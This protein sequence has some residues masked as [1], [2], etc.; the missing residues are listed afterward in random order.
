MFLS[1][2]FSFSLDLKTSIFVIAILLLLASPLTAQ[3]L[4]LRSQINPDCQVAGGLP[5]LRYSDIW[6]DGNIAV[7]G[8]YNCR[9][10]F[11]YDLTDPDAPVLASVYNPTPTQ[12]FLE[13]IVVGNRGYFGSGGPFANSAPQNGDGVHIVDLTDPYHPVL[14][15]KVNAG[16]G[17]GFNGIHEMNIHGN[18]L[19]ENYNN[20]NI[21]TIKII[22]VSDPQNPILRWD[23]TPQETFWVHALHIRGNRMYLSGW[24]GLIEIYDISNLA[25]EPP[26]LLG[27]IQGNSTNHSS[28]TSEDGNYLYSC[29]ETDDGDLRVYDV[30]N[31][32]EA[33]LVRTIRTSDLGINA[34]S[35][36]NPVV[37]GNYLYVSWYQAGVQV[38]D[39]TDPT[40]P[41]RIAQY[42]TYPNTFAP[43]TEDELRLADLK[44]WDMV[45]GA[46]NLQN[47]LPN[48][49]DGNWAVFPFLG[50]NKILAGDLEHGLFV[51]DASRVS[52]RLRNKVSDFDGDGKTDLSIF[53]Q[54]TGEWEVENSS[55][56]ALSF[57]QFGVAGDV[58]APG[59]YDGDGKTELAVFRP[60]NGVWYLQRNTSFVTVPFGIAGDVPVPGDYDADGKTDVAIYRPSNGG[61]YI[62]RSTMGF[63]GIQWGLPTDKP[64]P[65]DYDGDGKTDVAIWRPGN[66][67]WYVLR[68]SSSIP[69]YWQFGISTD[70]P[71]SADFDGNGITDFAV[72]RPSEG[73]WF[74][75]DPAAE[76]FMR[77]FVWGVASDQPIPADY[78]GDGRSDV[79][80]FRP[81]SNEWYVLYSSGSPYT[82]RMFGRSGDLP[83]P[84]SVNHY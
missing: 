35:P 45:C 68:S 13:A 23:L 20:V 80:I 47:A 32:A 30:R 19:I 25:N 70:K 33:T 12:A 39:L 48:T 41:K 40:F 43:P 55:S 9:G 73:S 17:G 49:Y 75:L 67:V 28:W 76:P 10:V 31:P 66:G 1:R 37:M 81:G 6:A 52:A 65:G 38:F 74:A 3:K 27:T 16:R 84:S 61:W 18:F 79:A 8:S 21:R 69:L 51:L 42:D 24:A 60:G 62:L 63:V 44:P 72:Y 11:I 77:S 5:H 4:R 78:D 54:P 56:N 83:T 7:Q 34:I 26:R 58:M 57:P 46:A 82:Q 50:Q 29:R 22:D 64:V 2:S 14:L 15:G 53:R 71:V 59:D 36:H